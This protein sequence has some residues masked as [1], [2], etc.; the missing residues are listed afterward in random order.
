MTLI[1][2]AQIIQD[3]WNYL[4]EDQPLQATNNIVNLDYWQTN[5]E[6]LISSGKPVGLRLGGDEN[7]DNFIVDLVHF[8]LV[9]IE[10]PCFTDG[11]GYSLA[12]IL[13]ET[14]HFKGEIRAVGD[15][16][17]DQAQ[18]LIR[19]GFDALELPN[20]ESANLA[21]KKLSDLSVFYQPSFVTAKE[22]G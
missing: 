19:V 8:S 2:N 6:T 9:A 3:N 10:I 11:R 17:P 1:K 13:R 14:N 20:E 16:L 4:V 5:K 12:K 21:L 15:I 18:Y 22:I 7:P